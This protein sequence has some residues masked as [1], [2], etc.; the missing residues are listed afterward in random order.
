MVAS[1]GRPFD[2]D[3]VQM[4]YGYGPEDEQADGSGE[5]CRRRRRRERCQGRQRRR[6]AAGPT[7]LVDP[8]PTP[9]RC[10]PSEPLPEYQGGPDD[11]WDGF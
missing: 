6:S 3:G 7:T 2:V 10:D 11:E 8:C 1:L 4:C 9:R 5:R